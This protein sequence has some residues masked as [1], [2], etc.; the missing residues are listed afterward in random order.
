MRTNADHCGP[1]RTTADHCKVQ[2]IRNPH[3]EYKSAPRS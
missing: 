1:L 3:A 2:F